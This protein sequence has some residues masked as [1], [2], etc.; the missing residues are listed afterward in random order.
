MSWVFTGIFYGAEQKGKIVMDS[1]KTT[2]QNP[3]SRL[4]P[5]LPTMQLEPQKPLNCVVHIYSGT[6]NT[7]KYT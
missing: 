5:T 4:K 2:V 7:C 6:P 3:D 1:V